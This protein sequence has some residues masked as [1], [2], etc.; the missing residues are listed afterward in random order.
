LGTTNEELSAA[1]QKLCFE[2][3]FLLKDYEKKLSNAEYL[4]DFYN[5]MKFAEVSPDNKPF[6]AKCKF[7]IM[8][9]I[10]VIIFCNEV[11]DLIFALQS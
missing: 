10:L 8:S 9:R 4:S 1:K 3:F 7:L 2:Y 5:I 6:A 11:T